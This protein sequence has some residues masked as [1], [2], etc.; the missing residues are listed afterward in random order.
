MRPNIEG[1]AAVFSKAHILT[2]LRRVAEENGGKAP[3]RARFAT[4]T[5]IRESDWAGRYWARWGDAIREAGLQPN[6]LN[7]RIDTETLLDALLD[8]TRQLGRFPTD[9]ELRMR[10]RR[11]ENFPSPKSIQRLGNK[12][13][14]INQLRSHCEADP[15]ANSDVL[16]V[17]DELP[18]QAAVT[19]ADRPG[20]NTQETVLGYVYL[21]RSGRHYKIGK[22]NALGRRERELA[23]QLPERA[24]TVHAIATDDPGGIELYWHRR[25]KDRRVRTDAEWFSLTTED[26]AAFKRRRFQ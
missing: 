9:A 3:G 22:T 4:E 10:R 21:I 26:V 23:I 13:E 11:D 17:L 25:F 24:K 14:L 18:S 2:E 5:G 8:V 6:S 15:V 19:E 16:A 7:K 12:Q 1:T 20:V